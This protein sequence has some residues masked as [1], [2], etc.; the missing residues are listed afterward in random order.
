MTD[1]ILHPWVDV[2]LA[3]KKYRHLH[4]PPETVTAILTA[5]FERIGKI[6]PAVKSTKEKLHNIVAAYLGDP[7]Y[8]QA[9]QCVATRLPQAAPQ[10]EQAI[11]EKLLAHHASTRE[12]LPHL[13]EFYETILAVT[14]RPSVILDLA[15]GLHPFGLPWMGLPQTIEY[16]AYDLHLPRIELIQTYFSHRYPRSQAHHQDILLDIPTINADVAFLFKEAH[17][18]EKRAKESNVPLWQQLNVDWLVVSLPASSLNQ[19][20]DLREGHRNMV[21][22]LLDKTG[23]NWQQTLIEVHGE[24]LFFLQKS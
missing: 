5:E 22:N 1:D 17:R 12:R 21:N 20:H 19:Q 7:D 4:I 14:G 11:C 16:H 23:I 2:I 24:M 8:E 6:K 13:R 10:E 9:I 18:I 3:S 15:C